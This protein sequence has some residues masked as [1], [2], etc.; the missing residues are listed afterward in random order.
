MSK[1]PHQEL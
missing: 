1:G